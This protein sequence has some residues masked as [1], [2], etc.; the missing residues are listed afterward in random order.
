M[1]KRKMEPG[2]SAREIKRLQRCI[3]DLISLLGLPAV[4]TGREPAEIVSSLLDTLLGMLRLDFVYGRLQNPM[5]IEIV[6][7][8]PSQQLGARQQDFAEIFRPWLEEDPQK[9][10]MAVPNPVGDGDISIIPLRLG[11]HGEGGLIVAGSRRANFPRQTER[12][13][14]DVAANQA[15]CVIQD[16]FRRKRAEEQV[17]LQLSEMNHRGKNILTLVQAVAR[18]TALSDPEHFIDR[19]TDRLQAIA[20]NQDLLVRTSW[21]GVEV[22]DLVCA[23]LS[24]FADLINDRICLDGPKLRLNGPAAQAIGMAIH[25]LATNAS[26]YGALSTDAGHVNIA[27]RANGLFKMEWTERN[28]PPVQPPDRRGFGTTVMESMAKQAVNGTVQL[29]Y[30]TAGVA[31]HLTCPAANALERR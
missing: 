2:H 7:A 14:L 13:L 21:T 8:A 28:G 17:R 29:E 26:K 4:W 19:F 11:L 3:N 10:P 20:A 31:W 16:I 6:R 5:P 15:A 9:W 30:E 22:D 24:Q 27:W 25:E 1:Q 12:L 18:Q 23:Q